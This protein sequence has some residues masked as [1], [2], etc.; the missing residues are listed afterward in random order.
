MPVTTALIGCGPRGLDWL[1]PAIRG[2]DHFELLAV[3]D[4]D[5]SRMAA[6]AEKLGVPAEGDLARL[7]ARPE[8][9]SIV[10]ATSA[11]FHVPVALQ[12]IAAGKHV[13]V[14]KPLADTPAAARQLADAARQAGVV[15]VV[16]YQFR[17]TPFAAALAEEVAAIEPVQGL[18][19]AHRVPLMQQFFFPDH[20]GGIMDDTTHTIH[21]ALWAMGGRPEG[22]MAHVRRGTIA[23]DRTIEFA[24]LLVDFDERSRSAFVQSSMFGATKAR[25]IVQFVGRRG[26]VSTLDRRVLQVARHAGIGEPGPKAPAELEV[27]T[28]ETPETGYQKDTTTLLEHFADLVAGRVDPQQARACTLEQGADTIAVMAAMARSFAE[29]RRVSLAEVERL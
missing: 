17:I 13:Y 23:G 2:S 22:V 26:V 16:G 18:L 4:V 3:C 25:N 21:L 12:A 8:L 7:L 1:G 5:S 28:V 9:Q 29:G 19:T 15:G 10:V 27:R 20:Y 24:S 11:R 14:E 6:A